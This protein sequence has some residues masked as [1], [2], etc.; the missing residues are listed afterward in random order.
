MGGGGK[1]RYRAKLASWTRV[2]GD[3]QEPGDEQQGAAAGAGADGRQVH[4]A[5]GARRT[6]AYRRREGPERLAGLLAACHPGPRA[7]PCQ[8]VLETA[9]RDPVY[10]AI[11]KLDVTQPGRELAQE[12]IPPPRWDE[13][14]QILDGGKLCV[15][16][17]DRCHA[18][19]FHDEYSPT[20]AIWR[21][22]AKLWRGIAS[23]AQALLRLR[24]V[25]LGPGR[26]VVRPARRSN[27]NGG[28]ASG[29]ETK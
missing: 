16:E 10:G 1:K 19:D 13:P 21:P 4:G 7:R 18:A 22:G 3:E 25:H 9:R 5:D 26:H 23:P 17:S 6:P 24:D 20:Y 28:T 14:R 11:A 2:A 29:H 12:L 27:R 15:G 8:H